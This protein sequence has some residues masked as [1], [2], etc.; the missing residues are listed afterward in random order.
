MTY[1]VKE[2]K[3]DQCEQLLKDYLDAEKANFIKSMYIS[4][5]R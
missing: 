2:L 5:S 4:L 1:Y 3:Y